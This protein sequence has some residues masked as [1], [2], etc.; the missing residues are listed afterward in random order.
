MSR[1]GTG[2]LSEGVFDLTIPDENA[3][4]S[5]VPGN[6]EDLVKGGLSHVTVEE[7][8]FASGLRHGNR[9]IQSRA[10]FS[11]L[12][13]SAADQQHLG[14]LLGRREENAR[15]DSPVGFA[16]RGLWRMEGDQFRPF[17]ALGFA[18]ESHGRHRPQIRHPQVLLNIFRQLDGIVQV[19]EEKG[20]AGAG[21]QAEE[22]GQQDIE[23]F[24]WAGSGSLEPR[25]DR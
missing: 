5:L 4:H 25:L 9:Q 3:G 6:T 14:L 7:D 2:V 20:K 16:G 11:F 13:R 22:H 17:P 15:S 23:Q 18:V 8:D 19:L 24:S 10:G 12:R 21:N 1:L